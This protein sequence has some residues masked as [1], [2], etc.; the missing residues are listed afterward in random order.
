MTMNEK[1][2]RKLLIESAYKLKIEDYHIAVGGNYFTG[3][4]LD[5]VIVGNSLK[6]SKL[7]EFTN[8]VEKSGKKVSISPMNYIQ[9]DCSDFWSSKVACMVYKGLEWVHNDYGLT[10]NWDKLKEI[11]LRD[12]IYELTYWQKILSREDKNEKALEILMQEILFL[13]GGQDDN[14]SS[15]EAL[16][17]P[18]YNS[19]R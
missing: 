11:K 10:M 12:S 2:L 17:R 5:L 15:D 16:Y 8:L 19:N 3:S 7:R 6:Y 1:Q 13:Q 9:A 18:S 4:D 14:L